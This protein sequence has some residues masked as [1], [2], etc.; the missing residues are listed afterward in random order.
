MA[1]QMSRPNFIAHL[2]Q[3]GMINDDQR[4]ELI[5]KCSKSDEKKLLFEISNYFSNFTASDW[6]DLTFRVYSQWQDFVS[7]LESE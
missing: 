7:E 5:E 4:D 2:N 1:P 6:F 3:M